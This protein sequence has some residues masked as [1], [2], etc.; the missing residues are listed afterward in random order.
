MKELFTLFTFRG[1]SKVNIQSE[2]RKAALT[3]PLSTRAP[4]TLV[5]DSVVA[6][7]RSVAAA[8]FPSI[9]RLNACLKEV[10]L[11]PYQRSSTRFYFVCFFRWIL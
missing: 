6:S 11:Y 3:R 7:L 2:L 8:S 5:G 1:S 4:V 10:L 9:P